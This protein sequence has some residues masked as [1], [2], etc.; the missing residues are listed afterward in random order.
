MMRLA[1]DQAR[2]AAEIGE[3]PVGAVVYR[4]GEVLASAHNLRESRADPT[5]H[6]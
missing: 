3:V 2:Q 1:L 4:G 6:A 5:A